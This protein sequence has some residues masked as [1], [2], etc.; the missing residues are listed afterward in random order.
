MSSFDS[1]L[2]PIPGAGSGGGSDDQTAAEVPFTPTGAITATDTQAAVEQVASIT[3]AAGTVARENISGAATFDVAGHDAAVLT[4]TG[5]VTSLAWSGWVNDTNLYQRVHVTIVQDATGGRAFDVDAVSGVWRGRKPTGQSSEA[6]AVVHQFWASTSDAGTLVYLDAVDAEFVDPDGNTWEYRVD[7]NGA[8]HRWYRDQPPVVLSGA[9]GVDV[10]SGGTFQVP[11]ADFV[12]QFVGTCVDFSNGAN[13]GLVAQFVSGGNQRGWS[14]FIASDGRLTLLASGDGAV[15]STHLF[16]GTLYDAGLSDGDRFS[17]AT[18]W[19]HSGTDITVTGFA[20]RLRSSTGPNEFSW[21]GLGSVTIPLA[22]LADLSTV[23]HLGSRRRTSPTSATAGLDNLAGTVESAF[24]EVGA[25]MLAGFPNPVGLEAWDHTG[26]DA[27]SP[28]A[29]PLRAPLPVSNTQNVYAF[30]KTTAGV[31][32]PA[33]LSDIAAGD[34]AIGD[35][36]NW[37][38]YYEGVDHG[39]NSAVAV[40]ANTGTDDGGSFIDAGTLQLEARFAGSPTPNQFGA[41]HGSAYDVESTQGLTNCFA[42]AT[43]V[44]AVMR[45][46]EGSYYLNTSLDPGG[47]SFGIEGQ[48]PPNSTIVL[49]ND[50]WLIETADSLSFVKLSGFRCENGRGML[51][52]NS[53]ASETGTAI[54]HIEQVDCLNYTKAG[55]AVLSADSPRWQID[56]CVF[57]S[58]DGT[59]SYGIF[60]AGLTDSVLI[61]NSDFRHQKIGL[62]ISRGPNMRVENC[63]FF[64]NNTTDSGRVSIWIEPNLLTTNGTDGMKLESVKFGVENMNAGDYRILFADPTAVATID[65]LPDLATVSTGYIRAMSIVDCSFSTSTGVTPPLIHSTTGDIRGLSIEAP[66]LLGSAPG[67]LIEFAA[68]V[69]LS[70]TANVNVGG[71]SLAAPSATTTRRAVLSNLPIPFVPELVDMNELQWSPGAFDT[72]AYVEHTL[73]AGTSAAASLTGATTDSI[74][75]GAAHEWNFPVGSESVDYALTGYT[76]GRPLWVEFDLRGVGGS[77]VDAMVAQVRLPSETRSLW[78]R[79]LSVGTEWRRYRFY[80][81]VS[82][83]GLLDLRLQADGSAGDVAIGRLRAYTAQ[84]PIPAVDSLLSLTPRAT[85]ATSGTGAQTAFPVNH[86]LNTLTPDNPTVIV[87]GVIVADGWSATIVDADN[88]TVNF[89]TAPAAGTDNIT[90]KVVA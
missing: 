4:L 19:Q 64:W 72:A 85:T 33:I 3:G 68:G 10:L 62:R 41:R 6:G 67:E 57:T 45:L 54:R 83:V 44:G 47:E 55:V 50:N 52:S 22:N 1:S 23:V 7:T 59:E 30:L 16:P 69:E 43:G 18:H 17:V 25:S 73:A 81:P 11:Q 2:G 20:A 82:N 8:L 36:L 9:S 80:S 78:T 88:L 42:Y 24:I 28:G 49:N 27:T 12:A 77:P 84:E 21:V 65:Q 60:L 79:H 74:G 34:L 37:A 15:S 39:G 86:G 13:Q 32:N 29:V 61:S 56:Q 66:K 5:D 70:P 38:S 35:G 75:G 51:L 71:V 48:G 89:D 14:M 63:A 90:I 40:A 53:T 58:T 26:V 76:P 46:E 31:V 87:D